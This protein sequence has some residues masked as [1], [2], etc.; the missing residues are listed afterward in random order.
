MKSEIDR[1]VQPSQEALNELR[2]LV[3]EAEKVLSNT[4][5]EVC[6]AT[7][8]ML[9][10]R[11]AKA[12]ERVLSFYEDARDSVV[13]GARRTDKTIRSHPYQALAIAAGVGLLAGVLFGRRR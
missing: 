6:E 3:R 4:S 7:V 10:Q 9:R 2:A 13:A 1:I 5:G 8:D 11:F 12:Q